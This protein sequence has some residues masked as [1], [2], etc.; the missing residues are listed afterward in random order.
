MVTHRNPQN[1][2]KSVLKRAC[3]WILTSDLPR[4]SREYNISFDYKNKKTKKTSFMKPESPISTYNSY[5]DIDPPYLPTTQAKKDFPAPKRSE[6]IKN[7][8]HRRKPKG[9]SGFLDCF[10]EVLCCC[11]HLLEAF[12]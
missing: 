6:A 12:N 9:S 2:P 4:Y 7:A 11:C 5:E 10:C 3:T 1:F 8:S